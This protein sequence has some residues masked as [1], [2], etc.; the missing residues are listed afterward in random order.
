MEWCAEARKHEN[1]TQSGSRGHE[2]RQSNISAS[3]VS[4]KVRGLSSVDGA[5]KNHTS[6]HGGIQ[7]EHFTQSQ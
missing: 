4:T 5:N 7:S 2:N 6:Q 1:G 3:N